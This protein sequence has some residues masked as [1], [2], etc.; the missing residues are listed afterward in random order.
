MPAVWDADSEL[1]SEEGRRLIERQFPT[2]APA[3]LEF[4]G[5]GWDNLAFLVNERFVFRFPRRR[6]AAGLIEREIRVL[7]HLAP[8]LSLPIPAPLFAGKPEAAYPYAFAGYPRIPGITTCQ[9]DL[10]DAERARNAAPLARFLAQ[11]HKIPVDEQ[12][13]AE[14]PGDDIERANIA[15]RA[16]HVQER[17][18]A[19]A[20]QLAGVDVDALLA[21]LDWLAVIPPRAEPP[22]WVH[23][24]L[25]A[26]HLLLNDDRCLCGVIDWGDVHLGDPALDLSI[27]FSFLPPNARDTFRQVYGPIDAA[28]WD[29]AQFRAIHYGVVLV[30]YGADVGDDAIRAI[31]EYALRTAL[32]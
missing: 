5:V 25:Y 8:H 15:K 17:L 10:S 11:L 29:R 26:R 16:P 13:R 3:R 18:R 24:D 20:P 7:P 27:A 19:L 9:T 1:S 30:S 32:A 4:F 22:C 31:G 28:T 12:T 2:L 14:G 6:I 23:G 21:R